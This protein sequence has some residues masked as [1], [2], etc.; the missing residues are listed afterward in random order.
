MGVHVVSL[1]IASSTD[2]LS[3]SISTTSRKEVQVVLKLYPF[4]QPAVWTS[5]VY[6]FSTTNRMDVQ[7]VTISTASSM[8]VE[9]CRGVSRVFT[10][11][12]FGILRKSKFIR[13]WC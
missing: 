4:P 11:V 10:K 7:G 2:I 13:K 6:P 5:R 3:V 8:D 12:A 9:G 1:S